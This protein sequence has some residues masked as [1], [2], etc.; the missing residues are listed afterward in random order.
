MTTTSNEEAI[1]QGMNMKLV[2]KYAENL[3]EQEEAIHELEQ[4]RSAAP[5]VDIYDDLVQE[6]A[7]TQLPAGMSTTDYVQCHLAKL[8]RTTRAR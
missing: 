2:Q 3:R 8:V 6:A 5:G 7:Q 1:A 4:I